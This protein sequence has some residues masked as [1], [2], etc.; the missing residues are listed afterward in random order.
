[1]NDIESSFVFWE[2]DEVNLETE[3]HA[4]THPFSFANNPAKF[5]IR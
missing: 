5:F 4:L 1:M 2:N 3:P